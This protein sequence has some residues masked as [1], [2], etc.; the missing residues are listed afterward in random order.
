MQH[1]ATRATLFAYMVGRDGL[2]GAGGKLGYGKGLFL[3]HSECLRDLES[4]C[5]DC[6]SVDG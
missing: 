2:A 3:G 5:Q 6:S 1:H 4:L